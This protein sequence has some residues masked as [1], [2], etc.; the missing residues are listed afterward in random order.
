MQL[1]TEKWSLY[2]GATDDALIE[3]KSRFARTMV[4]EHVVF[5]LRGKQ[6]D[7]ETYQQEVQRLADALKQEQPASAG[8][9]AADISADQL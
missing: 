8:V 4:L 5:D 3:P 9:P 7:P 1:S 2:M 6:N